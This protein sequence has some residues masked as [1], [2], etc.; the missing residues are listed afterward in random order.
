M[1]GIQFERARFE[2]ILNMQR[3]DDLNPLT[4]SPRQQGKPV[5]DLTDDELIAEV[6]HR[7]GKSW[8]EHHLK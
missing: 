6:D 5:A 1:K 7:L 2:F 4:G 3:Q 8:S